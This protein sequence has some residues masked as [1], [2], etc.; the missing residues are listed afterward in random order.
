MHL[1]VV[2]LVGDGD[3]G[4]IYTRVDLDRFGAPT[5]GALDRLTAHL[6][7]QVRARAR[8]V[9]RQICAGQAHTGVCGPFCLLDD[10]V[11][12]C[13]DDPDHNASTCAR[14][15]RRNEPEHP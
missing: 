5:A 2:H 14:C 6:A 11:K 4:A 7:A 3:D 1:L 12:T 15:H 10:L 13:P 9:G 8:A